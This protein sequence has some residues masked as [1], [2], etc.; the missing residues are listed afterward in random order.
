MVLHRVGRATQGPVDTAMTDAGG[1][2]QFEFRADTTANYLVSVRYQGIEYFSDPVATN[3]TQ[4]DSGL[5]LVVYDTST[6]ARITTKSRTLVV[7][8]PDAIGARTVIDWFVLQNR[9][10]KTRVGVDST[11]PTWGGLLAT[12]ARNTQVGDTRLSQFSPDAVEFR[13]DSV[14][15]TAPI[16]PGEK[17]LLVQYELPADQ[18]RLDVGF[19]ETDSVDLFLEESS[20]TPPRSGWA[21]SDS[22]AFEGRRFRRITRRDRS[23]SA[24]VLKFPGL[25]VKP[26]VALRWLVGGLAAALLVGAWRKLRAS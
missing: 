11:G 19:A 18:F 14:Y 5:R 17:E 15:V 12:A 26:E 4:P 6:T 10:D 16:S 23:I 9:G 8:A 25:G 7:S 2:F 20:V 1:R 13:G 24:V 21:V 22:Q 3:P